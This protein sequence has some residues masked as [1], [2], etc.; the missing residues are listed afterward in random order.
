[1]SD[2]KKESAFPIVC[3]E[4]PYHIEPGMTLRDYFAAAALTGLLGSSQ[5]GY[6][7]ALAEDAAKAAWKFA[8]A[9]LLRKDES[10]D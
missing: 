10:T 8:D 4:P 7:Y 1:M 2:P 5:P 6:E 3:M 9:M